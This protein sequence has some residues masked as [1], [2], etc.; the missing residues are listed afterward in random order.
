MASHRMKGRNSFTAT[1]MTGALF[2]GFIAVIWAIGSYL[3]HL[4]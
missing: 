3:V 1:F 2:L 4:V